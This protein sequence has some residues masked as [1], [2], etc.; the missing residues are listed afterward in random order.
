M[1]PALLQLASSFTA[2]GVGK[3][4]EPEMAKDGGKDLLLNGI[5]SRDRLIEY[6]VIEYTSNILEVGSP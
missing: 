6:T 2:G 5:N 4:T 3:R 1:D